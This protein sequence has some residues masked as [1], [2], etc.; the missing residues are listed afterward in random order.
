MTEKNSR[1]DKKPKRQISGGKI[2]SPKTPKFSSI[3]KTLAFWILLLLLPLTI[4]NFMNVEK[5]EVVSIDYSDF[6]RELSEENINSVVIVDKEIS[7]DLKIPSS[8]MQESIQVD[9][10]KFRTF[11]PFEDPTLVSRLEEKG[12]GISS[13]PPKG[14]WWVQVLGWLPWLFLL[15]L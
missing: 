11:I 8:L 2:S 3:S 12:V 1:G 4:Y 7:G 10:T 14:K 13:H 9:Y 6:K 5:D 15:G